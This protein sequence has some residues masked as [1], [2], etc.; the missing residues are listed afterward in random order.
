M[1]AV[2]ATQD[3]R[4]RYWLP[5]DPA[6]AVDIAKREGGL[7]YQAKGD[8]LEDLLLLQ[9]A[10]YDAMRDAEQDPDR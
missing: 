4:T 3:G 10:H 7:A 5:G 6:K 1:W 9:D 2:K 8:E